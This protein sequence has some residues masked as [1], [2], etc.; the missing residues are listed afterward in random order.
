MFDPFDVND[1]RSYGR[2][3]AMAMERGE[4]RC[5]RRREA[6][7]ILLWVGLCSCLGALLTQMFPLA[8]HI[9]GADMAAIWRLFGFGVFLIA[10]VVLASATRRSRE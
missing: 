1:P 6:A 8:A 4:G 7:D 2:Q 9:L 10:A 5:R 3:S